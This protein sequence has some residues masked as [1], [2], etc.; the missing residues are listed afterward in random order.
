MLLA[1]MKWIEGIEAR[2]IEKLLECVEHLGECRAVLHES[3]GGNLDRRT[4]RAGLTR[5]EELLDTAQ[6]DLGRAIDDF[7]A[8]SARNL[9]LSSA[10]SR[11]EAPAVGNAIERPPE[12]RS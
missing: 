12:R 11:I 2:V 4:D 7:F 3:R 10:A 9:Q 8:G 6:V 5:V 1:P